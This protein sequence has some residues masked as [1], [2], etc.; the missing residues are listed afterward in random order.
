M[1][2]KVAVLTLLWGLMGSVLG[3]SQ[4]GGQRTAAGETTAPEIPGVVAGGTRVQVLHTWE[5]GPGGEG[6]I[7][8]S[9]G[10]MLFTQPNANKLIRID[11][12]GTVSTYQDTAPNRILALA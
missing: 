9:D 6:P 2:S 12:R 8:M 1:R 10:S 4:A 7:G 5:R 3:S 11:P